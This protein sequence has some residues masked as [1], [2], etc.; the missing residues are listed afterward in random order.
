M[1]K[2]FF[3]RCLKAFFC[4]SGDLWPNNSLSLSS[5]KLHIILLGL[6]INR[7]VC[8]GKASI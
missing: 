4:T 1:G 8:F 7:A 2:L 3:R 6:G 5:V